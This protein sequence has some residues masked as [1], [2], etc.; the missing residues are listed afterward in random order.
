MKEPLSGFSNHGLAQLF[1]VHIDESPVQ[2][3][4][5]S[6]SRRSAIIGGTIGGF[7]GLA[8][9]IVGAIWFSAGQRKKKHAS[10]NEP[11]F[12]KD[13]RSDVNDEVVRPVPL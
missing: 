11:V 6:R 2:S 8:I 5:P 12:E 4:T 1:G 9:I 10:I 7:V 3:A 13:V